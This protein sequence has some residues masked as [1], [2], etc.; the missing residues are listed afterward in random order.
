MYMGIF[1]WLKSSR[2]KEFDNLCHSL[3]FDP[4]DV[5]L[6]IIRKAYLQENEY[7]VSSR[8]EK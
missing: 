6:E 8:H 1:L 5:T 4:K 3:E 7:E 2:Q